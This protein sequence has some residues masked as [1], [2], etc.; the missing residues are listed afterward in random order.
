MVFTIISILSLIFGICCLNYASNVK[1]ERSKRCAQWEK[2]RILCETEKERAALEELKTSYETY[3]GQVN[4]VL[5]DLRVLNTKLESESR[6][7]RQAHD[8]TERLLKAEHERA[9]AELQGVRALEEERIKHDAAALESDLKVKYQQM[10]LQLI[11]D[12][13]TTRDG[14]NIELARIK[15]ELAEFKAKREAINEAIRLEEE[16]KNEFEFRRMHIPQADKDDIK[17]LLSIEDKITN[18]EILRKLIWTEYLQ[19]P[20]GLMLKNVLGG[21]SPK[22]VIYCIENINTHKKYIGKTAGEV[23]KRWTEHI[24]SSLSIGSISHQV[25]HDKLYAHWDEFAFSIVEE[26]KDDKLSDR[27]KFYISTFGSDKYGYNMK[28]G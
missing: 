8:D 19:K 25:I 23:S 1:H 4:E 9:A 28:V 13:E 3:K 16:E 10:E 20:F 27:E 22:N 14:F 26:V 15:S 17:Y 5:T 11:S 18:K 24:K 21:R 7:A 12:F 2:W 6:R